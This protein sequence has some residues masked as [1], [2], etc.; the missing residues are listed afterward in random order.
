MN[1]IK[2]AFVSIAVATALGG[3]FATTHVKAPCELM[4]QYR[5]YNGSYVLAG[6]YGEDYFCVGSQLNVCTWYKPWPTSNWTPCQ[7]GSYYSLNELNK[8]KN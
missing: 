8:I 1:K 5:L 7:A 2:F 4:T 3:A 6:T